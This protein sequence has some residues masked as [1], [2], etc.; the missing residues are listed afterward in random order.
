MHKTIRTMH[1]KTAFLTFIRNAAGEGGLFFQK[2]AVIGW[3]LPFLFVVETAEVERVIVT[4]NGGDFGDGVIGGLQQTLSIV[5]AEIENV[6]FGRNLVHL[7]EIAHEQ[8]D[9]HMARLGKILDV[10]RLVV[11]FVEILAG[12]SHLFLHLSA[13][14]RRLFQPGT[15]TDKERLTDA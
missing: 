2:L 12:K 5:H 1:K 6:L 11:M 15:L 4:D 13:D 14:N 7:F 3:S 9:A 8:T 10:D